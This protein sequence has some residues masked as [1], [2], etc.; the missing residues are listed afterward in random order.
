MLAEELLEV[1]RVEWLDDVLDIVAGDD[2]D[3][4]ATDVRL[5][6][7]LNEAEVEACRHGDGKLIWDDTTEAVCRVA[8]RAG[9]SRYTLD[10]RILAIESITLNDAPLEHVGWGEYR[11]G[12][13]VA[14]FAIRGRTLELNTHA[15]A[16]DEATP[17]VLAVWREPLTSFD[18]EES[19]EIAAALHPELLQWLGWRFFS[20]P[21]TAVRDDARAQQHLALFERS[22]GPPVR[23]D[24]WRHRL[25][26]PPT[27]TL[28]ADRGYMQVWQRGRP[29]LD[30][31]EGPF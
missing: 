10:P 27:L 3:A 25:E 13:A 9:V 22:F 16:A 8:L 12:S 17:L 18:F 21:N 4:A 23:A 30:D 7:W 5:L 1:A 20:M 6:R 28:G 29:L 11:G 19:P 26:S 2:A 24:T 14:Q 15:Q 31:E